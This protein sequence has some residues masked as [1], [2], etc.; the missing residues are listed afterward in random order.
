MS[1]T[2]IWLKSSSTLNFVSEPDPDEI[3]QTHMLSWAFA[4]HPP[5]RTWLEHIAELKNL[6]KCLKGR[7][8]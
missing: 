1:R 6:L 8:R 2:F 4:Y 7:G 5:C 3:A